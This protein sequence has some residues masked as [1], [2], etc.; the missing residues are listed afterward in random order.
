MIHSYTSVILC[1]YGC[2]FSHNAGEKPTEKELRKHI[3]SAAIGNWKRVCTYLGIERQRVQ[4]SLSNNHNDVAEA[5]FD[6]LVFWRNGNTDEPITWEW[7][8]EALKE[9]EER[10]LAKDLK[11]KLLDG[12][13]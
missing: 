7:L 2:P 1:I 5:F 10:Q 12:C 6:N 3:C 11:S 9:A 8:L 13:L 4:C